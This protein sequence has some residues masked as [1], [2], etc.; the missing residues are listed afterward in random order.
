MSVGMAISKSE[1]DTRAGDITR[2]FQ[3]SFGDVATLQAF[4]QQ[5][6]N[7]D[8][9][10]LGYTDQE[11]TVLKSAFNDL[12]QLAGIW[13]GQDAQTTPYDFRTFVRQVWGVGSF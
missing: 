6:P 11:V 1:I 10:A 12:T 5:T 4:L 7:A 8:L 13:S 2:Q 3:Q 9:V